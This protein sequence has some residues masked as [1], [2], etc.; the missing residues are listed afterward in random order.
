MFAEVY[1]VTRLPRRLCVFDYTC[2]ADV[3]VGDLVR[4]QLK[5]RSVLGVVRRIKDQSSTDKRLSNIQRVVIPSLFTTEDVQRIEQIATTIVQSPS[6]LFYQTLIG[7]DRSLRPAA[8]PKPIFRASVHSQ[9]AKQI[10]HADIATA[11]FIQGSIETCIALAFRLS[12]DLAGQ[13]LIIA[14]HE[15]DARDLA[16]YLPTKKT[17][18]YLHGHTPHD[19]RAQIIRDWRTGTIDILVGTKQASLLPAHDLSQVLVY[20]PTHPDHIQ[21]DRNPRFDTVHAAQLIA[22]QHNATFRSCGP[23]PRILAQTESMS[24]SDAT[25]EVIDLTAPDQKTST[26]FLSHSLKQHINETLSSNKRAIVLYN[27]KGYAKRLQCKDCGH[28]PYCGS[29]GSVPKMRTNDLVC[30]VCHAEMWIPQTCP[31]CN[32]TNL[33]PRGIGNKRLVETWK[34]TFPSASIAIVDKQE[35]QQLDADI[36]LVTEYFF[37]TLHRAFRRWNVGV[38]ADACSDLHMSND[39]NAGLQMAARVHR[40][41]LFAQTQHAPCLVQTF[42]PMLIEP[43]IDVAMFANQERATRQT[44]HLPPFAVRVCIHGLDIVAPHAA[45]LRA[46]VDEQEWFQINDTIEILTSPKKYGTLLPYL[47]QL[48]DHCIIQVSYG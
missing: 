14:P 33:K 39:A 10:S 4:V 15:T 12:G 16:A 24:L 35:H 26:P 37:Q 1:P 30:S 28:I 20:H 9:I 11:N 7:I 47:Q 27:R 13:M 8:R 29:C 42:T 46:V 3:R 5:G 41:V 2:N 23:M 43:M 40:L 19:K 48:P 45:P 32:G 31:S 25:C 21:Y 18:A 44:Y 22:Q 36:L 34:H 38:V 6:T 17:V